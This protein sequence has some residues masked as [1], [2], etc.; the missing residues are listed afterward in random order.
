MSLGWG[1]ML[2]LT[3]GW[4]YAA[5]TEASRRYTVLAEDRTYTV[6]AESRTYIVGADG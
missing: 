1:D 2:A 3:I 5:I 4:L 6:P